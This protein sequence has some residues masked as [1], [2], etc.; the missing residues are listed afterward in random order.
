MSTNLRILVSN[1][2]TYLSDFLTDAIFGTVKLVG[3]LIPVALQIAG[4]S[5]I[6]AGQEAEQNDTLSIWGYI[7]LGL[8]PFALCIACCV[9]ASLK[10]AVSVAVKQAFELGCKLKDKR[11]ARTAAMAASGDGAA[12][13]INVE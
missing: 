7:C 13:A 6:V 5:L 9:M 3:Y 2:L 12:V 4:I 1:R 11:D 8:S 10:V